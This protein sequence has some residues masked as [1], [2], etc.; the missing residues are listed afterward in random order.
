ML[1]LKNVFKKYGQ[2]D[3]NDIVVLKNISLEFPQKGLIF[4]I[5]KSGSGKTTLMH[6][7]GGLDKYSSGDM[8]FKNIST[9]DFKPSNFDSYRNSAVGFVFQDYNLIDDFTVLQNMGIA[10]ELQSKKI[11]SSKINSV[12]KRLNLD[13]LGHR[14]PKQLSGGQQQRVAIARAIVKNPEIIMCDEPTGALDIKTEKDVLDILKELSKTKLVIINSHN[15]NAACSYADRIIELSDGNIIADKT[16][17]QN[18]GSE[19]KLSH[20]AHIQNSNDFYS[21]QFQDTVF[22]NEDSDNVS[23]YRSIKSRLPLLTCYKIIFNTLKNKKANFFFNIFLTSFSLIF[24]GLALSFSFYNAK[25]AAKSSLTENRHI[26]LIITKAKEHRTTNDQF[27]KLQKAYPHAY[28]Q[29]VYKIN[30]EDAPNHQFF[31]KIAWTFYEDQVNIVFVEDIKD[32]N[33]VIN[34][35]GLKTKKPIDRDSNQKKV[36]IT[37]YYFDKLKE[38]QKF[39]SKIISHQLVQEDLGLLEEIEDLGL[40]EEMFP[41]KRFENVANLKPDEAEQLLKD[42]FADLIKSVSYV[43]YRLDVEEG[44]KKIFFIENKELKKI[45]ESSFPVSSLIGTSKNLSEEEIKEIVEAHYENSYDNKIP[46]KIS[47]SNIPAIKFIDAVN[48]IFQ[49]LSGV[50]LFLSVNYIIFSAV[51]MFNFISSSIKDKIKD[52][53]ILKAI[54]ANS[55][56]IAKIFIQEVILISIIN[57]LLSLC[58][59]KFLI[60]LGNQWISN[61]VWIT[62]IEF[63]F[64]S[65]SIITIFV[66]VFS[67]AVSFMEIFKISF[68]KPIDI[69]LQK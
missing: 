14:F 49:I 22:S 21:E 31:S 46:F 39:F 69:I 60:F 54:G 62:L 32:L 10:L 35:I 48:P 59:T 12:L 58:V 9:K 20:F 4:I 5:G 25:T 42:F 38:Y 36:F 19:L 64:Y 23:I 57:L 11:N 24:L 29:T 67:F 33:K 8:I 18:N 28:F 30:K 40:L 61:L 37:Q 16:R 41:E 44:V 55:F 26:P 50:F 53:G 65:I 6:I 7:L 45:I 34:N 52:I 66:F 17:Q 27:K 56:D 13:N 15:L 51:L 43:L 63:G 68:K 2:N 1:K 47:L 3:Q